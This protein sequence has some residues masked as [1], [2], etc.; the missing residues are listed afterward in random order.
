MPLFEIKNNAKG[1]VAD[2]PL[3]TGA[4]TLNLN[5]GEGAKFPSSG[6]FVITIWDANVYPNPGDDPNMEIV[7][8]TSRTDDTLTIVR[9]KE[10]TSD[11]EH[12]VNSNVE[13]LVTSGY[14]K[15]PTYGLI[16]NITSGIF[17]TETPAGTINGVNKVFTITSANL[18]SLHLNGLYQTGGG[19]DYTLS[20]TTI[21]YVHAPP[22]GSG[23]K[24]IIYA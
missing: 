19:V 15:D 2:D 22:T 11:V 9:A 1:T 4:T 17:S 10:S 13:M 21:T 24:A 14:F 3:A 8:C 18:L 23:H 6:V 20:G 7:W 16:N 12:A 5:S